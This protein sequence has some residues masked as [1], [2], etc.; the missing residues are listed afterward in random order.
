MQFL[1]QK[2][3]SVYNFSQIFRKKEVLSKQES[4]TLL[5]ELLDNSKMEITYSAYQQLSK[6]STKT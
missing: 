1:K 4:R 6:S 2:A 3:L 5:L